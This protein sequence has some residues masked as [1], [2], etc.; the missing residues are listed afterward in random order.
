MSDLI[1]NIITEN[2]DDKFVL[3]GLNLVVKLFTN[4]VQNPK[5]EK[6]RTIKSSNKT[7][8]TK[9]LGLKGGIDELIIATGFE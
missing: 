2:E 4:I 3:D 7:I 8:E 9:I 1:S 6:Y 5:E